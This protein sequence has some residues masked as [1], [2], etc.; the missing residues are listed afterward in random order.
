MRIKAANAHG[1]LYNSIIQ[2]SEI[3]HEHRRRVV[4]CAKA[5]SQFAH[6]SAYFPHS[7][8]LFVLLQIYIYIMSNEISK[9][10]FYLKRKSFSARDKGQCNKL[11]MYIYILIYTE[12]K[13]L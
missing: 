10:L 13:D 4:Y 6:A 8:S 1:T 5:F 11:F 2:N 7:M 3:S 9:N 12:K